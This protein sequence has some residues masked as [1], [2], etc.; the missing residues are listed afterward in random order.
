MVVGGSSS[1]LVVVVV[2]VVTVVVVVV[3]I[4][5]AV[6]DWVTTVCKFL[7]STAEST[8]GYHSGCPVYVRKCQWSLS[9]N[10]K[11]P[12]RH[13]VAIWTVQLTSW[14]VES[15]NSGL[16][17][18]IWLVNSGLRTVIW[19]VNSGL[20]TVIWLVN[21][22]LRTVISIKHLP[23]TGS[24]GTCILPLLSSLFVS[25]LMQMKYC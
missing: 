12:Q 8:S 19:L 1:A 21:S 9:A 25:E 10:L 15:V 7:N 11:M 6:I 14:E 23:S 3:V 24:S 22:G 18:V 16:R 13:N 4:L 2:V 5:V 20:R 17:S